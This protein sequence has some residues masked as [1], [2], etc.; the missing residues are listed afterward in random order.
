MATLGPTAATCLSV[1]VSVNGGF[2]GCASGRE[3]CRTTT[4]QWLLIQINADAVCLVKT[5][6]QHYTVQ[7][8]LV[9]LEL[10]GS[11]K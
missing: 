6:F 5:Q 4:V 9:E 3:Y 7:A 11:E 1:S 8:S 2:L 10:E